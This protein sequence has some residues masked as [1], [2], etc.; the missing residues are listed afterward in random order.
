MKTLLVISVAFMMIA[1]PEVM[2][3]QRVRPVA[4]QQEKPTDKTQSDTVKQPVAKGP[5]LIEKFIKVDVKPMKGM[6][7]VYNQ[8]GKYFININDTLFDRDIIMVTRISKAAEGIRSSFDGYAGDQ[9]NS[10]MFRFEKGPNNKIFLRKV[11]NRERS[12]D[13]TQAMFAAVL[14]SNLAAIVATFEIKAQSADKRDNLIDVTDFFSSDS[15]TLFFRKNTKT[16]FRLGGMQKESSYVSAITTY[17]I[18]TEIKTVKTYTLTDRGETATY[19]L[20]NSFVLL[21]KV[22]M[23]PRYA[24]ERV[25]YFTTGYTDFD[26]N[27][28]GV[29]P[30]R[31]ITRWRLEPKPEDIEKYKRGELVE[32]AKPIV[33]YIDPATPKEWVPYLIQGVND[34]QPVFEKAGFKNAI[35]ALEATS[36]QAD[37]EWS[38]EDARFSAIVY[39]PSDIPNASGP[40][41]NDPRS[42]EIIESHINWYHN[43]MSLVRNWYFVQCSPVDPGARKMLFDTELMGQLVR[44]VSSHEVGHTLG[45]R[46]NFAGTA[47]YTVEQLRDPKFLAENGHTTSIM[48]YSRFNYV[49]QPEDNIP[50]ELLFPRIN[51]YDNWCIEWGYRRFPEIDDPVKELPKLNQWIIEKTKDKRYW[52][53]TET[54]ANDPRL[55]AE[56]L[57]ENQM[58]ANELGIRNLKVVM[59][60]LNEWTKEP[61]KDY[62]NLRTMH[63]EVNN[64]YRRYIGHVAKWIGGIYQDPKTVEMPGD[65]YAI[66]EKERQVEAMAFLKRH[67]FDTPPVWLIPDNYMNKFVSRNETYLERSYST[68]IS[69]I[70]SRRV[71]MNLV[72]AEIAQGKSAYTVEDLFNDLNKSIW[73]N[74]NSG[75]GV[76]PYKRVLQKVYVTTLADLFTGAATV[77]RMGAVVK[78]TS[79]PKDITECSSIAY[80]QLRYLLFRLNRTTSRDYATHAHNLYLARY[81]EKTL[82]TPAQ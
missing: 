24:D 61:N 39:K 79:N 56:D 9:L 38:L 37:P 16:S 80:Y 50:R 3:G 63:G 58:K 1:S 55:Q 67:L 74:L 60:N 25:G 30:V 23:T 62:E 73:D 48:D 41:V 42:G 57:G 49:A 72:S 4:A 6:T 26:L 81:I 27:P 54:S 2:N 43:V 82:E 32:P 65:V 34:W 45:M 19:E 78:P 35:Y 29:K 44:F 8:D 18:N 47:S 64:Q 7:T 36:P 68:A 28:Q 46:H 17:P 66:V 51:H 71:L 76:D 69:S 15:E 70:L 40:H 75:K 59:A 77:A 53:G 10:G 11:L 20:N 5:V 21:P 12:K 13:S 31:M 52:F 22:P 14:R 33:F